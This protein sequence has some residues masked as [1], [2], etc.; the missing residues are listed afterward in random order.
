MTTSLRHLSHAT[1]RPIVSRLSGRC[2]LT[3]P[4]KLVDD[5]LDMRDGTA[6]T[7]PLI[8][9]GPSG[10]VRPEASKPSRTAR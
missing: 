2:P 10:V 3:G 4:R 7:L 5:L 9:L 1:F 8:S 6:E